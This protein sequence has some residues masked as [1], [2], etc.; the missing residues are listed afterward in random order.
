[1]TTHSSR[2]GPLAGMRVI[3]IAGLGPAPFCGMLLG[4]MG[5]DVL[6]VERPPK[7]DALQ[8]GATSPLRRSR[9][10]IVVDLKT[11]AGVEVV[12]TLLDSADAL[13]EGFRPGAMERLGLGPE[14]VLARN[15][16]LV[17]GRMTGWGQD[18]PYAKLA[19]HDINYLAL[20]GTLSLIGRADGSPPVAPLNLVGDFGGGGML[21]AFGIVAAL[22]HAQRSGAGQV[23]DAAML[24]GAALLTASIHG[25]LADGTWSQNRGTNL[26]DGGAPFYEVYECADGRYVAVGALE[27]QFYA[28]LLDR[29]GLETKDLTLQWDTEW[30]PDMKQ[31]FA[32]LFK[33]KARDEW[34]AIAEG[35][36]ACLTPVLSPAEAA[37][38]SHNRARSTFVDVGGVQQPAPAP[39]FAATPTAEPTAP[40]E[41]GADTDAALREA[42]YRDT[43]IARLREQGVV[44]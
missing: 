35:S 40:A 29:A 4:D 43:D 23:V 42:G 25:M 37:R 26:L 9:R 24:D 17:Y 16:R 15:P 36:D 31:R 34:A 41:P 12:G 28:Q 27:P 30:W 7:P 20:C 10:S 2:V 19:G 39:R 13:I 1:M 8:V 38:H 21:L 5:A 3:E 6:V 14:E 33:Q 44:R 11:P 18:G 22:W 32:A